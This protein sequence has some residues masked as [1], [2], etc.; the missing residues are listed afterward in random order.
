MLENA[1]AHCQSEAGRKRLLSAAPASPLAEVEK[2]LDETG[3]GVR[4]W[5]QVM[6]P[7]GISLFQL[8]ETSAFLDP[9]QE[10][11]VPEREEILLLGRF[12]AA[13]EKARRMLLSL[14]SEK[15]PRLAKLAGGIT[16]LG[17]LLKEYARTF[18]DEGEVRD[19]ASR[20][21]KELRRDI[22][23]LMGS[24][25]GRIRGLI[26]NR[27]P[28][29]TDDVHL[30]IRNNRLTVNVPVNVLPQFKGMVV[31]YSSSGASV[32]VEPAEVVELNN[33]RQQLFLA[34]E[35]EVRRIIKEYVASV[36]SRR[37]EVLANYETLVSLDTI[38]GRSRYSIAVSGV[39]PQVDAGG[40]I[41]LKQARHP[42]MLEGFVPEDFS[43]ADGRIAIVSGV[44]AGGKSVL[45]KMA[46]LF[47]LM[48]YCG[49]YLPA[50]ERTA[51]GMHSGIFVQ[52]GDEQSV[53]N[54]LSTFTAH[55]A[56]LRETLAQLETQDGA[57]PLALVLIDE[58][59]TGTDPREG[60]ALG[61]ALLERLRALPA[62]VIVTTHYDLIKTLGEKYPD[63]KNYSLAFDEE[64]L[65]PSYRVLEGIPGASFAFHIARSQGLAE[66]LLERA[67]ELAAGAEETFAGVVETLHL[68]QQGLEKELAQTRDERLAMRQK[69]AALEEERK[70]MLEREAQLRK[71]IGELKREFEL[72]AEEFISQAKKRL[73][74]KLRASQ[75]RSGLEVASEFSAEMHAKRT[76]ALAGLER[77]LGIGDAPA[78]DEAPV[79]F[80]EGQR[81]TLPD[82]G[83]E[84][85]I[86]RVDGAH[87]SL[88]LNVRGKMMKLTFAKAAEMMRTPDTVAG[89]S[90]HLNVGSTQLKRLRKMGQELDADTG[91]SLLTTAHQLDLHGH[92]IEEALPKLEKFISD[93]I[94]NDFDTI[95]IMHGVGTGALKK[96]VREWLH[97]SRDVAKFR[98]AADAEGGKGMTIVTL[99]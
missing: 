24:I 40:A 2:L 19:N 37:W 91:G 4:F 27:A 60:A 34:E 96:F 20:Q 3:E 18:S 59:G 16:D 13:D 67:N 39:R 70:K 25:E 14:S 28:N 23:A 10:G 88:E 32:Y 38:L 84:A 71:Q 63:C 17:A 98:D 42:L 94:L 52:I 75:G 51:V 1:A 61:Y 68:K 15:Y 58:L 74:E 90:R 44:N 99:K 12:L 93:S 56:F 72:R 7:G 95:A 21:L 97:K 6:A 73:R 81:I 55:L 41:T 76:S 5:Q 36:A 33:D 77:E 85:E 79:H 62:K 22:S 11:M 54:N 49:M 26:R 48:A 46:G 43:F 47:T 86:T 50:G 64:N 29:L 35:M 53:V 66:N 92:T 65:K 8:P 87:Q 57:G 78:Q 83:V 82:L 69:A 9:F 30:S 45:L 31:D 89:G 80:T